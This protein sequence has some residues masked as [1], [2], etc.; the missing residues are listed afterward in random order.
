MYISTLEL[1]STN[2]LRYVP[3]FSHSSTG[4]TAAIY[5]LSSKI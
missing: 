5:P 4:P 2:K 3:Q 1:N